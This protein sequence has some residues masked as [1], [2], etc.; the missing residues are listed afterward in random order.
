MEGISKTGIVSNPV[1]L[2][3][4]SEVGRSN[5]VAHEPYVLIEIG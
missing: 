2:I 4:I 5:P 1:I 3:S